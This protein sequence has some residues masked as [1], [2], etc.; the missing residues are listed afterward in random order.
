M[1]KSII[2]TRKIELIHT[3]KSGVML[4]YKSDDYK[5]AWDK[6]R[7]LNYDVFRCANTMVNQQYMNK[8]IVDSVI[9][10]NKELSKLYYDKDNKKGK[11][12][13]RKKAKQ[14][15]KDLCDYSI[16]N[17]SYNASK[18]NFSHIPSDI[19]ACLNDTIQKYY[20]SEIGDILKGNRSLRSYRRGIP[21]PFTKTKMLF[22]KAGLYYHFDWLMGLCFG[23]K[24]GRDRSNNKSIIEK[25][26][27]GVYKPCNSSI[28]I[29]GK[30]IFLLLAVDIGQIDTTLDPNKIVGVDLG[31][32]V[33]AYCALLDSKQRRA[34]GNSS[35]FLKPRL[36]IQAQ[37]RSL[38]KSLKY[39]KGGKGRKKKLEGLNKLKSAERNT[40]K[41]L[42]HY[43]S[44]QVVD[45]ALKNNAATIALENLKGFGKGNK[46]EKEKKQFVLRNWSYHELQGMIE[47]KAKKYGIEVVYIA[48]AYTSQ[49][50]HTC[51]QKG[52]RNTQK[53]FVCKNNNCTMYNEA[54][55]ADYNA[56]LN[57]AGAVPRPEVEGNNPLDKA[58]SNKKLSHRNP[59]TTDDQLV[60][61]G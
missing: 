25:I 15:L 16:R 22:K 10:S 31:M 53:H 49:T 61:T 37:R 7:N 51:K 5:E 6:I 27:N 2:I 30:K 33:P 46:A 42:N 55:L 47:Y 58:I 21:I 41:T 54:V 45:F 43:I 34:I 17:T 44:K 39:T 14:L 59:L 38:Q 23:L 36:K 11:S 50:C 4:D 9:F 48:P 8:L 13:A 28:Q 20:T 19:R 32:A 40:V 56:A 60:L 24:F 26:L 29:D 3:D 57:I 18:D 35:G 52:E 12:Q 1:S